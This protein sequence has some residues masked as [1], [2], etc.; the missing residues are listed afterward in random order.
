MQPRRPRSPSVSAWMGGS[1]AVNV[2]TATGAACTV[3]ALTYFVVKLGGDYG[4]MLFLGMPMLHGAMVSFMLHSRGGEKVR[5]RRVY[6]VAVLSSILLALVALVATWEGAVCLLM[7]A[8]LYVGGLLAGVA[9]GNG[10]CSKLGSKASLSLATVPVVLVSGVAVAPA[11]ISREVRV[12]EIVIDAP[13]E[14][15]WPHVVELSNVRPSGY[16]LFRMGVAHPL[17]T[18][19]WPEGRRECRLSTGVMPE[20]VTERIE[21]RRLAFRVLETPPSMV[22]L[23][24]FGK[25]EAPH[26]RGNFVSETGCFDLVP[27]RSGKTLLRGTSHYRFALGPA[28]YW[29]IWTD[30][31][32]G[33]VQ[34][35]VLEEISRRSSR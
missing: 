23:N 32:V 6:G 26:L 19:T 2:L 16:W 31:I 35:S 25:V 22:E 27:L 33:E 3:A 24:P 34:K 18:K 8:P 29:R 4:P 15:V 30:A 7:A 28:W 9:I 10:I 13:P 1:A 5:G 14:R 11:P 21:N 12:T 17:A 20:V